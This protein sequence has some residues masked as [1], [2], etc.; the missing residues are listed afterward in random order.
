MFPAEQPSDHMQAILDRYAAMQERQKQFAQQVVRYRQWLAAYRTHLHAYLARKQAQAALNTP[1]P[2]PTVPTTSS[3][4]TDAQWERVAS[5][6]Y[7]P[8]G[9]GRPYIDPRR[10]LNGIRYVL[11]TG[12]GWNHMPERYGN[13]VTCWRR[14][15]RWQ[16][17]GVWDIAVRLLNTE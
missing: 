14:L 17:S 3:D 12:C 8:Q 4:V 13:Y 15:I 9:R 10:T 2:P 11:A 5:L 7:L 1:P 16:K 6:L